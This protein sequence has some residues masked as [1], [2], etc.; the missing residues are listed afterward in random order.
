MSYFTDSS[1]KWKFSVVT[2]D[3]LEHDKVYWRT[4]I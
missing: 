2:F 4:M 3:E 1:I